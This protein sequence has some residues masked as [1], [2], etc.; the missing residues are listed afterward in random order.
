VYNATST[1][2]GTEVAG[3]AILEHPLTTLQ[4]PPGWT[5]RVDEWGNLIITDQTG[6]TTQGNAR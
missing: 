5:A 3:P 2:P 4:I 6:T 1:K